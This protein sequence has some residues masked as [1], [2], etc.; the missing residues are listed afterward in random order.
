MGHTPCQE[1]QKYSTFSYVRDSRILLCGT[2]IHPNR[3]LYNVVKM[4]E[5]K[6]QEQIFDIKSKEGFFGIGIYGNKR[7]VNLGTLYRSAFQLGAS[8]V[9]TI[10]AR[11]RKM[12]SDTT[13]SHKHIPHYHYKTF[14]EFY[15]N[16]IPH[17]CP[18]VGI[19]F[20][21]NRCQEL[22]AYS[23]RPHCVYLLGAEDG[24]LPK[25]IL[26]SCVDIVSIPS[27]RV[28]SYNVAVS[29]SIVMYDRLVKGK[30]E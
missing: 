21:E 28:S 26:E 13:Y 8:F 24:G 1:N 16:G 23:H 27:V 19:E 5:A 20:D 10:G 9:F 14:E 4:D 2:I 22:P 30:S 11:Y 12:C 7:E 15:E 25:S 18:L 6:E 3:K 17:S 29:G